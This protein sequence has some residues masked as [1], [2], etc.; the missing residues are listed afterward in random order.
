MINFHNINKT[1]PDKTLFKDLNLVIK[2]GTRAGL[3]GPNG[4]GKTTLLRMIVREE[5][6]DQGQV[7]IDRKVSI[8]YLP[9]E[10]TSTSNKTILHELLDEIPEVG[11]LEFQIQ[12]LSTRIAT[13][14]ENQKLLDKL[15]QLQVEFDR[16]NGWTLESQAKKV[17][18]GLGFSPA[19]MKI[20]LEQFSGGW[21]MRVALA[22]LLFKQPDIL[23][24]DEPT[25]HLDLASLIWLENFL[26]EWSGALV[27]ISHDRTFLDR[28][29]NQIFEIHDQ[30]IQTY[31]GNYSHFIE[32]KQLRNEQ[33]AAA[34]KN[35]QKV[36]AETERFIERFRYKDSK[37][38]QVQSRVKSLAKL[39]RIK[40]PEGQQA[41]IAVRIPQP[42]RSVR[43]IAELHNIAKS[44]G[45]L[46]V[47]TGLDLDLERGQ[48]IG[49]V[50][51]NGAGKST[52]L[53]L[54]AQVEP[55]SGG[56]LKWGEGVEKAYFAQHQFEALPLE[57]SIFDLIASEIPKWT[58]TEVRNYLG[59][60]L[61]SGD[62]IEKQIKVL[63]G[64]EISR[65]ALAKMLATPSHLILLD[66]PT[67]HLDMLSRDVV[68]DAISNFS[69]TMVCISHDRHFLN[70]V[71]NTIVEVE[72]GNIQVYPGNYEYYLWR[73]SQSDRA[74]I[75]P[76][77]IRPTTPRQSSQANDYAER[78]KQA[79]RLKKLPRLINE[80]EAAI[81]REEQI[82]QDPSIAS[83]YEKI[84]TAIQKKDQ[85]EEVYLELLEE[86][87]ILKK[88]FN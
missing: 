34:Y 6:A 30:A 37:A 86:Q 14:P 29:I 15:G 63:S 83:E 84:Q 18:G 20:P 41:R 74:V 81:A 39:E 24:L 5:D 1:Y 10:I 32:E 54:L 61:F 73:K 53:K 26:K 36:I 8:G 27:L 28:S 7:Q 82:L 65:L 56:S 88:I 70:A 47:F 13:E 87:E 58:T 64:G 50:G 75:E 78:K 3:V 23:L 52:L 22:K 33:Q 40:P 12:E 85:L 19:Q 25:N 21:R 76:T 45:S 66:E 72:R 77:K 2:N 60:F 67:N 38:T 55:L 11:I 79:N 44:Y 51:P 9:Q 16:L 68:Q 4:S 80:C 69:G 48:K 31:T 71:T 46:E 43:M 62:T 17:L 42:G 49:L 35:Q 57:Q 59:S